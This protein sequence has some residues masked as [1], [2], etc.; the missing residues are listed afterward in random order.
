MTF[1]PVKYSWTK[2]ERGHSWWS[3]GLA[4]S[5]VTVHRPGTEALTVVSAIETHPAI[6]NDN[7]SVMTPMNM[8][9]SSRQ[10]GEW[11][12]TTTLCS[13]CM[14]T[15][16][17]PAKELLYDVT[18]QHVVSQSTIDSLYSYSSGQFTSHLKKFHTK[19]ITWRYINNLTISLQKKP[20]SPSTKK[21]F[22]AQGDC[23]RETSRSGGIDIQALLSSKNRHIWEYLTTTRKWSSLTCWESLIRE[24]IPVPLLV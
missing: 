21:M 20:F 23:L 22:T 12:L 16:V 8:G 17:R 1:F 10:A 5:K 3:R 7:C 14:F 9:C 2:N 15:P 11:M 6:P 4:F 18:G 24:H 13:E 19:Y